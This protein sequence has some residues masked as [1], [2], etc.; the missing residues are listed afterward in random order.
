MMRSAK[1]TNKDRAKQKVHAYMVQFHILGKK[2]FKAT[3][4]KLG[5]E[6]HTSGKKIPLS[7]RID[8]RA[9]DQRQD[10]ICNPKQQRNRVDILVIDVNFH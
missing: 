1:I 4:T 3:S 10:G 2:C 9:D 7:R 5:R 8:E 6:V